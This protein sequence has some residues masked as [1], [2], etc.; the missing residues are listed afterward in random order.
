[1]ATSKG[2]YE[3]FQPMDVTMSELERGMAGIQV[4]RIETE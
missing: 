2:G 3:V 4:K 1:M